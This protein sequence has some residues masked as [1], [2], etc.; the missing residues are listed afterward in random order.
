M[1]PNAN[2]P[3]GLFDSASL[4]QR[5]KPAVR[6]IGRDAERP[7]DSIGHLLTRPRLY[8]VRLESLA[9]RLHHVRANHN[10]H[11]SRIRARVY[12]ESVLITTEAAI[13]AVTDFRPG[14]DGLAA[15]SKDLVEHLLTYT[16][17]PFSAQQFCPGHIT[18]TALVFHPDLRR[19]LLM[20]HHRLHRWLLPG[21][22][23]EPDD[24]SLPAAAA[25][26]ALEETR[27]QIDSSRAPFLAGIDVH[28]IPG[29]PTKP[30]HL[31]H[32][33][34]WCFR[35]LSDEFEITK[36]APQVLWA[37]ESDWPRLDLT[38]SIQN[39]IRRATPVG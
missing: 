34:I 8:I 24:A 10:L 29:G 27:V 33:L 35:A 7:T 30:Y 3:I 14:G 16:A 39:S 26:E 22:H 6:F 11:F 4:I 31:H 1:A 25:R 21:G 37:S 12:D 38:P 2:T 36:E 19:V 9:D 13:R 20:H 18:C 5:L 23:V 28:G 17:Q 15:K 32:D